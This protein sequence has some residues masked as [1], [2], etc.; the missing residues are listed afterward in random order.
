M[1]GQQFVD[2]LLGFENFLGL[3][4]DVLGLSGDT[5]PGL[6]QHD[7]C[8]RQG[9]AFAFGA[10]G[11]NDRCARLGAANAEGGHR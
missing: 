10:S 5:A 8:V 9:V 4:T 6:M 1:F 7:L 2:G 11:Q 3:N